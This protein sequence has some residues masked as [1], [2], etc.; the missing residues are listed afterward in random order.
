MPRPVC[1][2]SGKQTCLFKLDSYPALGAELANRPA[3]GL[4]IS[5]MFLVSVN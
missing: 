2:R 5:G 1:T 3:K 4:E